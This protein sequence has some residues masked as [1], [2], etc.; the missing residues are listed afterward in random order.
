MKKLSEKMDTIVEKT[1]LIYCFD[2]IDDIK[3][4]LSLWLAKTIIIRHISPPTVKQ[5]KEHVN[6]PYYGIIDDIILA[7]N[8]IIDNN[9]N[10]LSSVYINIKNKRITTITYEYTIDDRYYPECVCL[11]IDFEN[12]NIN[13]KHLT[14]HHVDGNKPGFL[15]RTD[16]FADEDPVIINYD[17]N[18]TILKDGYYDSCASVTFLYN[19]F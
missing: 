11:T 6:H 5:I 13:P 7:S 17:K 2:I 16:R 10:R 15:Y 14:I 18:K 12:S 8:Y 9:V 19:P 1:W 3:Q 4:V